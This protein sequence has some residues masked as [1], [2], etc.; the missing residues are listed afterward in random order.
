MI[1]A[2]L[3]PAVALAMQSAVAKLYVA[4]LIQ[5]VW[6][7][8]IQLTTG[9]GMRRGPPSLPRPPVELSVPRA[10][11]QVATPLVTLLTCTRCTV[12]PA[13]PVMLIVLPTCA[14]V[15]GVPADVHLVLVV[16][17]MTR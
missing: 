3:L 2:V 17:S 15:N 14:D 10:L 1:G 12:K 7:A 11:S 8:T 4:V 13:P 9:P 6:P 5:M 16:A